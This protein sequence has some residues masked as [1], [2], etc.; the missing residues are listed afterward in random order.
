M[1]G[2]PAYASPNKPAETVGRRSNAA[3]ENPRSAPA[4]R[5][6][7]AAAALTLCQG[8]PLALLWIHFPTPASSVVAMKHVCYV[9]VALVCLLA[10]PVRAVEH[11]CVHDKLEHPTPVKTNQVYVDHAHDEAASVAERR[12]RL[13]TT[14]FEPIRIKVCGAVRVAS[15]CHPKKRAPEINM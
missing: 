8:D 10:A 11:Q 2:E 15:P 6:A 9:A 12:R 14:V 13:A 3:L 4:S 7:A 1:L 5:P